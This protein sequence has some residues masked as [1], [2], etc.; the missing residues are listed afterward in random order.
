VK[1]GGSDREGDVVDFNAIETDQQVQA[2][3]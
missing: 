2:L 1:K 3:A